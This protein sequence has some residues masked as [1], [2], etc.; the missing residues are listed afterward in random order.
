MVTA[1]LKRLTWD[2]PEALLADLYTRTR[3]ISVS[4]SSQKSDNW[5]AKRR[6]CFTS[7]VCTPKWL[8][9]HELRSDLQMGYGTLLV[10]QYDYTSV[11]SYIR[12]YVTG[13]TGKTWLEA[14][15]RVS[16]LG[17]WEFDG[18]FY[19]ELDFAESV[20]RADLMIRERLGN[21][22]YDALMPFGLQRE[23]PGST[24][25]RSAKWSGPFGYLSIR[26]RGD[27]I[28]VHQ[29]STR[30]IVRRTDRTLAAHQVKWF[31]DETLDFLGLNGS[32]RTGL[33]QG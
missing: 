10:N 25:G 1:E 23:R 14:A 33:P 11:E 5:A 6:T 22:Y 30:G 31:V 2:S 17:N 4:T 20:R 28:E 21:T 16:K 26:L 29:S 27:L 7:A 3:Q 13:C 15:L 19:L 24:K 9:E 32:Q 18:E 12:E 8:A